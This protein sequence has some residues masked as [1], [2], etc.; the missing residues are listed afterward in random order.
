MLPIGGPNLI[1][2]RDLA[3]LLWVASL[4]GAAVLFMHLVRDAGVGLLLTQ[5]KRFGW[6]FGVLLALSGLR[7]LVRTEA[8]RRSI[9]TSGK[10][11][12]FWRLFAIRL[13][14][15]ALTDLTLAGPVFGEG[16]RAYMT[17]R[18]LDSSNARAVFSYRSRNRHR[19]FPFSLWI[20]RLA[21]IHRRRSK[22]IG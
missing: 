14:S 4:L 22:T 17:S 9:E 1:T 5:I 18:Y 16:A 7:N 10:M 21:S 20:R 2:S 15:C 13:V 8:W 6:S 12:G 19:A 3:R 11:P